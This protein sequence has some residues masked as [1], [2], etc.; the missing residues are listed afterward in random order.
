MVTK[1]RIAILD[2]FRALA[3]LAVILYHFS[4]NIFKYGYIGVQLFFIISGFVI[5]LTLEKTKYFFTFWKNRFIRLYPSMVFAS[6]LTYAVIS[7]WDHSFIF[8]GSHNF[9]N[10]LPAFLFLNPSFFNY[11]FN[12]F[13]ISFDYID[14]SYWTLWVEIQFYFF[15]SVLFYIN[16]KR[17]AS[18]FI[19][20]SVVLI[21]FNLLLK[22]IGLNNNLNINLAPGVI[23][24]SVLLVQKIF[25]LV[26]YLS[27]FCTGMLFY[28]LY[29]NRHNKV[30]TSL[31][32]KFSLIFFI[33]SSIY[34]GVI[35][36]ERIMYGLIILLFFCFVHYPKK[37]F[38]F[39]NKV[40]TS[41]GECSYF[42][43]LIH[44]NIGL[45]LIYIFTPYFTHY[46]FV[47]PIIIILVIIY[48]SK[49]FSIKIDRKIN[50][51]LKSKMISS[52][53]VLSNY[54]ESKFRPNK[55]L[56]SNRHP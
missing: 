23:S 8:P 6:L 12:S 39:E 37:L 43:Y 25:N 31:F 29:K 30:S 54:S 24:I 50:K 21:L 46:E 41:I 22:D 34:S 10:L 47:L 26:S 32:I 40:F 11:L 14:Y 9:K 36:Q 27:F 45:L 13:K 42:L 16:K 53:E 55:K 38:I 3:I 35:I 49:L 1:Y 56:F 18:N 52:N 48:F 44:Q 7:F 20:I 5:F 17:F 33:A 4:P 15:C 2:G 28:I 51:W 19:T